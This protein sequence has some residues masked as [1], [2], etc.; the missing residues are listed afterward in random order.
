MDTGRI[1]TDP[2]K[3]CLLKTPNEKKKLN[4]NKKEPKTALLKN[5]TK[6]KDKNSF[7][8]PVFTKTPQV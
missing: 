7:F 4:Q 8:F 2:K 1:P 3:P 5:Q 6:K